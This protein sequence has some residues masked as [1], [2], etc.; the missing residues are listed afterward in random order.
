MALAEENDVIIKEGAKKAY[1][2]S[3]CSIPF[4]PLKKWDGAKLISRPKIIK[5][6]LRSKFTFKAEALKDVTINKLSSAPAKGNKSSSASKV[7]SAPAGIL[8]SVKIEDDP[9]LA[10]VMKEVIVNGNLGSPVASASASAEGLIP[11]KTAEQ[12]IAKKKH[13]EGLDKTYDRF[14]KLISQLEIHDEVISQE[15]ANLKLLRSL[16]SAWNNIVL[17][18]RNKSYPD[19]LSMDDLY[20]NLKVY[21]FEI[22]DLEHI[23]TDDLKEIDLKWKVVMLT[24]RVK[25]FIKKIGRKLDLNGKE[26]VSFG[27]TKVECYNCHRRGHFSTECKALR[28][29]GNRNRDAPTRNA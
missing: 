10:I 2:S 24:M 5:S 16:P 22:K 25:R 21:E 23:D 3:V 27:R 13:Q 15:D 19:T 29:Q 18:M 20:N 7:D 8:K 6:I 28:I 1:E 17:I 14:Q 9:S 12:K 11:F 26:T 4:P